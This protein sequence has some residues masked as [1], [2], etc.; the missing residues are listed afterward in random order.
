MGTCG[1][2]LF[3]K[4]KDDEKVKKDN[5]LFYWKLSNRGKFVRTVWS[6]PFAIIA[7]VILLYSQMQIATKVA[8]I[9]LIFACV[10]L[11][12]YLTYRKRD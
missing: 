10:I 3:M 2:E 1:K 8:S 7:V 12:L 6:I 5:E 4:N 9:F 11:Q